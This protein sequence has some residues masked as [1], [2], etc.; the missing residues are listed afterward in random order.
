M[1]AA[2][3]FVRGI[4]EASIVMMDVQVQALR[5]LAELEEEVQ[6]FRPEVLLHRGLT[7]REIELLG[8]ASAIADEQE[9]AAELFLSFHA[10]HER[11]EYIEAK[12]DVSTRAA[13]VA[14]ALRESA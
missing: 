14:R 11:L 13:A 3:G 7:R 1:G 8:I 12:L 4:A 9:M 10:V 2:R 6:A 5:G